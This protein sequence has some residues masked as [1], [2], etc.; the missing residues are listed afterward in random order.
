MK[1]VRLDT[2]TQ[3]IEWANKQSKDRRFKL[4]DRSNYNHETKTLDTAYHLEVCGTGGSYR[5]NNY[6]YLPDD[7]GAPLATEWK[8]NEYHRFIGMWGIKK[9]LKFLYGQEGAEDW[10]A[11]QEVLDAKKVRETRR[12]AADNAKHV[13][14]RIAE[15]LVKLDGYLERADLKGMITGDVTCP[16]LD[17][18]R[19]V[20][21]GFLEVS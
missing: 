1:D 10:K 6:V 3:F 20:V 13:L 5:V 15:D 7:I 19:Y 14:D 12:I 17:D 4:A 18:V 8:Q 11:I 21:T 16:G 2:N 9:I